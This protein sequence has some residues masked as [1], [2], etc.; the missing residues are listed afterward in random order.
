MTDLFFQSIVGE[1]AEQSARAARTL[2]KKGGDK[3]WLCV[4]DNMFGE[5]KERCGKNAEAAA[6]YK[7]AVE[8]LEGVPEAVR[9]RLMTDAYERG[10]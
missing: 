9:G 6:A 1:Q 10:T 5:I 2:A 3:L 4:A 8:V 7:E